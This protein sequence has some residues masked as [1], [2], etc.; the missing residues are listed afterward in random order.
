MSRSAN[1]PFSYSSSPNKHRVIDF[2]SCWCPRIKDQVSVTRT[3]IGCTCN[4]CGT[5][6]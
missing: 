1:Y 2:N 6:F 5:K 3:S 4:H